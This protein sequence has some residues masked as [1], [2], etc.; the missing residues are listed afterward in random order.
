MK[1]QTS[2]EQIKNYLQGRLDPAGRAAFEKKL[3]SDPELAQR[4]ALLRAEMAAAELLIA[5][6]TRQLFQTWRAKKQRSQ[7]GGKHIRWII[8]LCAT[9]LALAGIVWCFSDRPAQA[10]DLPAQTPPPAEQRPH[11][12]LP[13]ASEPETEHVPERPVASSHRP[14]DYRRRAGLLLPDPVLPNYRRAPSEVS[15]DP[16]SQAQQAYAAGDYTA[17]LDHLAQA[18]STHSQAAA[19]LSAHA[20]FRLE[21]YGEAAEQFAALAEQRSRQYRFAAEWGLLLCRYAELPDQAPAFQQQLQAIL[22][23]PDHPYIEKAQELKKLYAK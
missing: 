10:P 17:A 19:F 9:L 4:A 3:D 5:E 20:L 12:A 21:R 2:D 14:K 23:Q 22:A 15:D 13:Q 8:G 7:L 16:V 11:P 1:E 6:D 18:D